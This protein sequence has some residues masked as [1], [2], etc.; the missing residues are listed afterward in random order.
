[1]RQLGAGLNAIS[2]LK[3]AT[4]KEKSHLSD[5]ILMFLVINT[6]SLQIIPTNIIAIR[7]SLCSKNPG[8]IIMGVWFSSIITFAFIT[9]MTKI[10]LKI[11]KES[12]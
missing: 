12:G 1:M 4:P 2:E 5:E 9:I 6:A 7:S 10:Y 11:R 3:E 8:G